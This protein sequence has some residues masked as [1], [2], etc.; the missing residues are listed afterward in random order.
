[1]FKKSIFKRI[2]ENSKL[3]IEQC[4]ESENQIIWCVD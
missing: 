4:L 3:D 2:P 1:M